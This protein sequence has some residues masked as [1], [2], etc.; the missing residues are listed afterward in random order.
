M[1][2]WLIEKLEGKEKIVS[3][4]LT[5]PIIAAG[6]M[7][8]ACAAGCPY[9]LVNDPYPGQCPR[10]IDITGDGICDLSQGAVSASTTNTTDTSNTDTSNSATM[11]SD[12]AANSSYVDTNSIN[13]ENVN[14]SAVSDSGTGLYN[15]GD[16]G[17]YHVLPVSMLLFGGYFF[18]H[19]LFN[20]GI[21]SRR[22]HRRLWNLLLTAGYAGTGI[23]GVLL[24]FIINLG[25]KTV[26]N[27]SITYWH[28]ELAILMVIGTL[29]H[30]H[31]YKK[32]LK[33]MFKVIFRSSSSS[34]VL[35]ESVKNPT[36]SSK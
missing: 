3:A 13:H 35:K 28:G 30:L 33:R 32:P 36:R 27:P 6:S 5:I 29:I 24:I 25:V 26:L 2:K 10:Y 34:E 14:A 17:G 22:K 23:T 1:K 16:G 21:L 19:F 4:A 15:F 12:H 20:K 8:G 31:L 11:G 9:G 7:C 18:T